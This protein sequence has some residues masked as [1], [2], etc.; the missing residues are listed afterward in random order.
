MLLTLDLN[1]TTGSEAIF[2]W[3]QSVDVHRRNEV[4]CGSREKRLIAQVVFG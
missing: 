4:A 1:F 2:R 3:W